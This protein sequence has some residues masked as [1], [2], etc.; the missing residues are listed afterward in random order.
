MKI[1]V[2]PA[3]GWAYGDRGWDLSHRFRTEDALAAVEQ[4]GRRE[5]EVQMATIK[6]NNGLGFSPNGRMHVILIPGF[7]GFDVL[8]QLEYY[9]GVTPLLYSTPC[10]L[11]HG[12]PSWCGRWGYRSSEGHPCV[13]TKFGCG[14][15]AG[16]KVFLRA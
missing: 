8:G 13:L 5:W 7:A 1:W 6:P 12:L 16:G 14:R 4:A 9:A 2:G 11:T 3:V 10:V 15:A